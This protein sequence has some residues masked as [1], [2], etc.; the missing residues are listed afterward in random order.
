MKT[1]TACAQA[2]L[3]CG[4]TASAQAP[5]ASS[6]SPGLADAAPACQSGHEAALV[7]G[8]LHI[9]PGETLCVRLHPQGDAMAIV[10]VVS[11]PAAADALS[12][13]VSRNDGGT[14]LV[15]KNPL[16]QP[17]K[18]RAWVRRPM[19]SALEYTST[20]PLIAHGGSYEDW[21]YG[22]DELVVSDFRVHA[23]AEG[24]VCN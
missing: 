20:C 9:R 19:R 5:A 6:G 10:E 22:V 17:L 24:N 13:Q 12:L 4:A 8:R 21:P 2:L 3:V 11:G 1:I 18:Y 16:G 14:M 23:E 15:L 7:E